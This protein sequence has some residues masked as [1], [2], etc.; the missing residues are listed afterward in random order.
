[1]K[2]SGFVLAFAVFTAA[3]GFL[4]AQQQPT[5]AVAP[6]EVI[7]GISADEADAIL[8]VFNIRLTNSGAVRL[9]DRG[10]VDRV[11]AEH[12]WQ[13]SYWSDE[14]KRAEIGKAMN[15]NWIVRGEIQRISS[16][17]TTLITVSFFDINTLQQMPGNYVR[18]PSSDDP[19]DHIE[20]LVDKL[21]QAVRASGTVSGTPAARNPS[22]TA[23]PTPNP[24]APASKIYKIGDLGPAGGIVFYDKGIFSNG[25]RYLEAAPLETEFTAQWGA[26]NQDVAGTSTVIGSGKRNTQLIVEHLNRIGERGRAAVLVASLNFDGFTDWFI[27]SRD[28]L[29]LIHK[30]LKQK[31]LGSFGVNWYWSSSEYD[32]VHAWSLYT[33]HGLSF[34]Q[35]KNDATQSVRAV[36]AF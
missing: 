5:V 15:A 23:T 25:W 24:A 26:Y 4:G 9:V 11:L 30:N 19:F 33:G 36:R 32:S 14:E 27:P 34:G 7:S 20:P 21:V 10:I 22:P 17:S 3:A 1:M 16:S 13:A 6:F 8:R 35:R 29:D 18:Y 12:S 2:I 31:N 28:E